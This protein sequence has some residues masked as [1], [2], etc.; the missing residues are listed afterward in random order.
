MR[1]KLL[2]ILILLSSIG[3]SQE[4][5]SLK[6]EGAEKQITLEKLFVQTE[7]VG[8][9][10][11]TTY[12]MY[13]YNPNTRVLEGELS[14]PLGEKQNVVRFA[15][16]IN[17][18]LRDAVVVEKEKAR[19]AFESTVRR[20]IDPALLEKTEGN[21]YKA[22]VYPIPAKGFKRIVLTFEEELPLYE[23]AHKLQY[24][25]NFKQKLSDFELS[26]L[27]FDQKEVIINEKGFLKKDKFK[28]FKNQLQLEFAQ[29]NFQPEGEIEICFPL[30][31]L[32]EKQITFE[33]YFYFYKFLQ[34]EKRIREK[35]NEIT[36]FW[37]SSLSMKHRNLEKELAIL[38]GFFQENPDVKISLVN[39]SNR[40]KE[41][42]DF[43]VKN[44]NWNTLKTY[45]KNTIYDGA[46]SYSSIQESLK[47]AKFSFLFTDGMKNFGSLD[48]ELKKPLFIFNSLK[49]ANHFFLKEICLNS[50]G[51]Y[52]NLN[53]ISKVEALDL[54]KYKAFSFIGSKKESDSD[55][56]LYPDHRVIVTNDFSVTGRDFKTDEV[57]EL[58]FGYGNEITK[59]VKIILKDSEVE[60]ARIPKFWA[61]KKIAS[62]TRDQEKNEK[63]IIATSK[64]FQVL[65][66]FTS[67]LVLDRVEDYVNHEIVP[68]K[69]LQERY[70][71]LLQEKRRR[72]K[73]FASRDDFMG[74]RFLGEFKHF[75]TWN[76]KNYTE[77]KPK[78]KERIVSEKGASSSRP[79]AHEV[80]EVVEDD[81]VI[82]DMI[83]ES[84][85]SDESYEA[86]AFKIEEEEEAEV[87]VGYSRRNS[88]STIVNALQGRAPG[89]VV[90]AGEG[91]P[92]VTAREDEINQEK[93]KSSLKAW[94]SQMKY[95]KTLK[96][97]K[98]TETAYQKYL[99]LRPKYQEMPTFYFDVADF[100]IQRNA[101]EIAL[102]IISNVAEMDVDNFEL[103]RALAYKLEGTG[104]T[105]EA[106]FVYE[107]ILELRPEDLQSYRDLA[108]AYEAI[109]EYQKAI[110]LL[111]KIVNGSL[112]EKDKS[113]RY[114]GIEEISFIE[115]NH[116]IRK[117]RN[118][119]DI[120]FIK[121]EYLKDVSMDLRVVID[122][123][124]NDTDID[125]WV[126]DPNK[127]KCYFS[128][129]KT[130]IYGRISDD[131]TQG[132]GPESF[133]LRKLKKGNYLGQVKY[134]GDTK[135]KISG[136]TVLK[137]TIY[138][139]KKKKN[140]TREVK[141]YRLDKREAVLTFFEGEL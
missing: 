32:G 31:D 131:M 124:H 129:T 85:K 97:I 52:L 105:K 53:R 24:T 137:T 120:A 66:D 103:L 84:T 64:E 42:K 95:V 67:M 125:L 56:E 16:E 21:N 140:E 51:N 65:S 113:R 128:H 111:Y 55:L 115:M 45:L 60:S 5:P 114:K 119:V 112:Y 110:A 19:V 29:K 104:N 80:I 1:A 136:P 27:A 94:D 3:F 118:K 76:K 108:L 50:G 44:R 73:Q 26:I 13:F 25:F 100:F 4:I 134:Y 6:V 126:T 139:K 121:K 34:A 101:P 93:E 132:F 102:Q 68:P 91:A 123:N 39:F 141:V 88:G 33:E 75:I 70:Y 22:R 47:K 7:V 71:S 96:K 78:H 127:E 40:I 23:E 35:T 107:K 133:T 122:W 37:D 87:E 117:H 18:N 116:I 86:E 17:G 38:D 57:L 36:V 9:I 30:E 62:L 98:L 14:F 90:T 89:V 2:L 28:A 79:P 92:G 10:A 61:V 54:L 109:G 41:V 12:E 8:N 81:E 83:M 46:T 82:E 77:K 72:E 106:V 43:K 69:D 15:L 11:T 135:Q 20:K 99:E 63:E 59:R 138:T 48:V 49:K 58:H 130:E 74:D